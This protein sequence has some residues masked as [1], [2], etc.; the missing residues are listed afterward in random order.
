M[1]RRA[2]RYG[3]SKM[4]L[5]EPGGTGVRAS[6]DTAWLDCHRRP[7]RAW[8]FVGKSQGLAELSIGLFMRHTPRRFVWASSNASSPV[9]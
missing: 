9:A 3:H 7:C 2:G 8:G 1:I 6:A 4:A 5:C